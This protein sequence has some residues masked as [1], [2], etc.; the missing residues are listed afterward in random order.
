MLT[1]WWKRRRRRKILARPFAAAWD[2]ALREN[3]VL[4]GWLS[5]EERERLRR[6]SQVFMAEKYWEGCGGLVVSDEMKVTIAAQACLLVLGLEHEYYDRLLSVLVYP[7]GY[8]A[9]ERRH[10]PAGVISEA[11]EFRL[12]E[13]WTSGPVILSWDDVLA[14]G[15]FPRDGRNVVFHEF[16]HVLDLDHSGP[17][18]TP[19]LASAEQYRTWHEVMTAEYNRLRR[20]SERR[21]RTVLD[22]YGATDEAEFFAVATEAFFERPQQLLEQHPQLYGL[23]RE[24]YRQEPVRWGGNVE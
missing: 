20:Q 2:A 11:T 13:A 1:N 7:T 9:E 12:G 19:E 21:Q 22:P 18:G 15:R 3:F 10:L 16:A 17:D 6:R 14:G 4:Y 24:F 5:D 8:F 23:L